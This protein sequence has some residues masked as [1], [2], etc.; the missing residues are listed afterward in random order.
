MDVPISTS[1]ALATRDPLF[2]ASEQL[3]LAGCWL[4]TAG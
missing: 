1:T 4:V 2:S 3:A